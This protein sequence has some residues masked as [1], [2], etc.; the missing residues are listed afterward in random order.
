MFIDKFD[1]IKGSLPFMSKNC[2]LTFKSLKSFKLKVHNLDL[3]LL[4]NICNNLVKMPILE[5]L[6]LKSIT[7][8]DKIF[9]DNLNKKISLMK[10]NDYNIVIYNPETIFS[11]MNIKDKIISIMTIDG[12]II[13]KH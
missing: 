11:L 2:I 13:R 7:L 12:I 3:E 8:V 5:T 1:G 4:N 6:E 10:I 9:F